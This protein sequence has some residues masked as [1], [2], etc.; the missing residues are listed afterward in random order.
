MQL[1]YVI[2]TAYTYLM[3]TIHVMAR[4]KLESR[5]IRNPRMMREGKNQQTKIGIVPFTR[6]S[7]LAQL[8]P[9]IL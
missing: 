6:K 7:E 9:L 2:I 3:K 1:V 4:G 8:R 5:K